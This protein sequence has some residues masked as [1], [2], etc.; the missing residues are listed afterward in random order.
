M[1]SCPC[2]KPVAALLALAM[3]ALSVAC[4]YPQRG[5]WHGP[6]RSHDYYHRS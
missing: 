3:L 4:V 2:C 1:K 6:W 5:Y